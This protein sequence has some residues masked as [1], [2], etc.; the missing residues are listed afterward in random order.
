VDLNVPAA[1]NR[2]LGYDA[3]N[4]VLGVS[5]PGN[6]V[7]F[8]YDTRNRQVS[9]TVNGVT[10]FFIWDGWDL[11]EERDAAGV[12]V[13]RYVHGARKDELLSKT[14]S[15]GT[16]YYHQDV[17]GSVTALTDA[18]GQP[19]ETYRYDIYGAVGI[20]DV[21]SGVPLATSALGN[22]FLYT[23]REWIAE[24]GLYDYRNRAY[25]PELGR[26]LQTDPILFLAGDMNL[27]RYV[28]NDPVDWLDPYGTAPSS[29]DERPPTCIPGLVPPPPERNPRPANPVPE[30]PKHDPEDPNRGNPFPKTPPPGPKGTPFKKIEPV[31]G[32]IPKSLID[33]K[34]DTDPSKEKNPPTKP[35]T[36]KPKEEKK[37]PKETPKEPAKEKETPKKK[38]C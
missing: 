31:P 11:I 22:R 19:K 4:R 20:W 12:L 35:P 30:K 23:G 28:E 17:L 18:L 38:G 27:Y 6:A 13:Q 24:A 2:T 32:S 15:A 36:E 9:R 37:D 29:G 8:A 33:P 34:P 7:T 10:T 1:G 26:F 3:Q 21:A 14:D 25:L 5:S 16:V